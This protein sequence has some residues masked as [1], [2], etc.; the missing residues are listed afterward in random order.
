MAQDLCESAII[1]I[2]S[3][4]KPDCDIS[5]RRIINAAGAKAFYMF[6]IK[7][8]SLKNE[9]LSAFKAGDLSLTY[10]CADSLQQIQLAREISQQAM[11]ELAGFIEDK[12]FY[13]GQVEV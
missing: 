1:N 4:L 10:S 8:I 2:S 3:R 12:G 9:S 11:R 5:D 6:C 13:F 7:K